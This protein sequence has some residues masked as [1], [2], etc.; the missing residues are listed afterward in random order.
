MGER[1]QEGEGSSRLERATDILDFA[2]RGPIA[3]NEQDTRNQVASEGSPES[4]LALSGNRTYAEN[5]Q[6]AE[7]MLRGGFDDA[8]GAE[9]IEAQKRHADL[10]DIEGP[11]H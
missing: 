2:A 9:D 10:L 4:N 11:E 1:L 8:A 3:W 7:A 6:R 5:V